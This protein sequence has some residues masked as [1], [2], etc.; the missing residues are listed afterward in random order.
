MS[1]AVYNILIILVGMGKENGDYSKKSVIKLGIYLTFVFFITV[2]FEYFWRQF[3]GL[4]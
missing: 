1:K 3:T 2:V 4:I